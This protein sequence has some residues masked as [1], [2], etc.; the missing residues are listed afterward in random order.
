MPIIRKY[1]GIELSAPK[2][3]VV[4]N[5]TTTNITGTVAE[6]ILSTILIPAN[7]FNL[8]DIIDIESRLRKTNT[9]GTATIRIRIGTTQVLG[10]TLFATF[11]SSAAVH[12]YIPIY[13]RLTIKNITT[14]TETLTATDS[15]VT[16]MG[17]I[18]TIN[19]NI[20]VDW[21][22]DNYIIVTGQLANAADTMNLMFIVLN[23]I[24][25]A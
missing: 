11:T 3:G 10:A 18:T 17:A 5:F 24:V 2:T 14:A 9:N 13:R 8:Y 22:V 23:H 4:N 16:D 12:T 6:T 20:A 21:T 1:N 15:V 25:G 19:T 7:T